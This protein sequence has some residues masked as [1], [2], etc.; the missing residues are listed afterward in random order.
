MSKH[1]P[2][3]DLSSLDEDTRID[4]IGHSAMGHKKTVG[5]IV[6]DMS[7]GRRYLRKLRKKF[8]GIVTVDAHRHRTG[9][10][11]GL[12]SIKV[13]PPKEPPSDA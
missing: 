10:L 8:P 4:T 6:D 11:R 5:F 7:K 13:G 2:I 12:V 3:A 9:P 1:P